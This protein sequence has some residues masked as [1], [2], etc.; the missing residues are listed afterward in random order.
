MADTTALRRIAALVQLDDLFAGSSEWPTWLFKHSLICPT[1][2]LALRE[3]GGFA[4]RHPELGEFAV[5]E[6]QRARDI[7]KAVAART[8]VRHESPQVL[9]LH[10]GEVLWHASHWQ[11]TEA[12]LVEAAG[13]ASLARGVASAR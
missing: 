2:D 12:A 11:I 5:V 1:S 13:A 9:L 6:I 10:K 8:G 7:S 4:E 3:F